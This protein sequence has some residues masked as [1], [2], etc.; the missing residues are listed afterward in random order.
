MTKKKASKT[1]KLVTVEAASDTLEEMTEDDRASDGRILEFGEEMGVDVSGGA[2]DLADRAAA[3]VNNA[4]RE[5]LT[6][7]IQLTKLKCE[8]AHGQFRSLVEA[9]GIDRTAAGR[10]MLYARFIAHQPKS[11]TWPLLKAQPRRVVE[12]ARFDPDELA[13]FAAENGGDVS[14]LALISVRKIIGWK[15]KSQQ[16]DAENATLRAAVAN[17]AGKEAWISRTALLQDEMASEALEIRKKLGRILE[18]HH[19]IMNV[20]RKVVH[21]HSFNAA[22]SH[23]LQLIAPIRE[24]LDRMSEEMS[25]DTD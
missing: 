12:L 8:T 13:A 10:A 18:R 11:A 6:V 15:R 21:G 23:S 14:D 25:G 19:R 3:G 20:P 16:M 17:P 5:L 7:G 1:A 4:R 22:R 2:E 9:R 24:D